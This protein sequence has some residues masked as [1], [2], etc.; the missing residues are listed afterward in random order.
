MVSSM[1]FLFR[2]TLLRCTLNIHNPDKRSS[3]IVDL[4]HVFTRRRVLNER[5]IEQVVAGRV[6]A[7]LNAKATE[8]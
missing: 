5:S 1:K 2:S 8:G 6:H 4:F 3:P 7:I